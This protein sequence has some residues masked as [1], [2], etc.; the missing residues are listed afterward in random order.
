MDTPEM[1]AAEYLRRDVQIDISSA[2]SRGWVLVMA[3]L[4]VLAGATVLAWAIG[5]GLGFLPIIGWAVG[6]LLGSVL[7]AGVLYMFIRRIRGEPVELGD[8]FAGFNVALQPLILA[9]LLV[10]ALTAAP[11]HSLARNELSLPEEFMMLFYAEMDVIGFLES[12]R[13]PL[14]LFEADGTESASGAGALHRWDLRS[15]QR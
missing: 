2:I 4:P 10:S 12:T 3:N 11:L 13:L 7:H 14:G 5:V 15:A 9:G 6:L 8:M 1:I